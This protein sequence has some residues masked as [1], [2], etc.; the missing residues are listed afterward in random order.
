MHR[1]RQGRFAVSDARIRKDLL[2]LQFEQKED[3]RYLWPHNDVLSALWIWQSRAV[4]SFA[5]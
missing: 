4:K 3:G 5:A 1:S 2:E